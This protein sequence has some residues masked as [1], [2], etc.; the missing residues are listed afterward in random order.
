[1]VKAKNNIPEDENEK[2]DNNA[3]KKAQEDA[4]DGEASSG[5]S[6]KKKKEKPSK[7]AKDELFRGNQSER[8]WSSESEEYRRKP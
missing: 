4:R 7:K 2:L 3:F 1:M 6:K 5:S 8:E